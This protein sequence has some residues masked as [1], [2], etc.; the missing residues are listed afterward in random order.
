MSASALPA[1]DP[2]HIVSEPVQTKMAL[3]GWPKREQ[4]QIAALFHGSGYTLRVVDLVT[5]DAYA[6]AM[7]WTRVHA[8]ERMIQQRNEE[9][10]Q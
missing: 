4:R 10:E 7:Q 8:A 1:V 9:R 5:L 6:S 3:L 2:L